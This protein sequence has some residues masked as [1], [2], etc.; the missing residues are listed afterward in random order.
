MAER[1]PLT[2]EQSRTT[3]LAI[4]RKHN[5]ITL[6]DV[7]AEFGRSA[8]YTRLLLAELEAQGDA[9][10]SFHRKPV[11]WWAVSSA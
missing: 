1:V 10:R 9:G 5:G 6:Q 7:A 2:R 3:I 4:L 11:H 8:S